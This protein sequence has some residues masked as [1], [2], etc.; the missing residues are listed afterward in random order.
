MS[1][2]VPDE[3]WAQVTEKTGGRELVGTRCGSAEKSLADGNVSRRVQ[4]DRSREARP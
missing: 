3:Q 1:L 4:T 2:H